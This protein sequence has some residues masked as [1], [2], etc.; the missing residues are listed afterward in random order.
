MRAKTLAQRIVEVRAQRLVKEGIHGG[1]VRRCLGAI[2]EGDSPHLKSFGIDLHV[3]P[4]VPPTEMALRG[5][6]KRFNSGSCAFRCRCMI[7]PLQNQY[8]DGLKLSSKSLGELKQPIKSHL[9]S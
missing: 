2:L 4:E 3:G 1:K 9:R 5:G 6:F 8:Y 7:E